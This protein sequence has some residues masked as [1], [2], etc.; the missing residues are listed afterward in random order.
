MNEGSIKSSGGHIWMIDVRRTVARMDPS[1]T[2]V[3]E[4]ILGWRIMSLFSVLPSVVS[5]IR[6]VHST[7]FV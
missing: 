6:S 7:S 2:Q 4:L 5:L 3:M 1:Y